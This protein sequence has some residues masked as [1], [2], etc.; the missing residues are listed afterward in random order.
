[1]SVEQDVWQARGVWTL[2]RLG[3]WLFGTL[4]LLLGL[5][6][7]LAGGG[8]LN[9]HLTVTA[10]P[11]TFEVQECAWAG[12]HRECKGSFEDRVSGKTETGVTATMLWHDESDERVSAF[13]V[14]DGYID[15]AYKGLL[16]ADLA[17]GLYLIG[18]GAFTVAVGLFC[19]VTGYS[20]RSI[21]SRPNNVPSYGRI[22]IGQAWRGLERWKVVRPILC[23]I[24]ALGVLIAAGGGV[25]ALLYR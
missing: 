17:R 2:R 16:P 24:A 6:F 12:D 4:V 19:L 10:H 3:G 11:G 13:K 15:D 18:A 20:P 7:G 14:P 1:M 5:F 9:G 22:T 25:V 8:A 23:G 21:G